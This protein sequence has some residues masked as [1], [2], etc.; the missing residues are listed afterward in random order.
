MQVDETPIGQ[1][2]G[3]VVIN[4]LTANIW[5]FGFLKVSDECIINVQDE[6]SDD[7]T[8]SDSSSSIE[9]DSGLEKPFKAILVINVVTAL[10]LS[11]F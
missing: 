1:R 10:F 11:L 8:S 2:Q 4:S 9:S 5:Q 6:S 7:G 3:D